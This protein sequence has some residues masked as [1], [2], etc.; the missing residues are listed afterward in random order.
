M[1]QLNNK[2]SYA[3]RPATCKAL[4]IL[5]KQNVKSLEMNKNQG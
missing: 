4:D 5:Y 3:D 2:S 1:I